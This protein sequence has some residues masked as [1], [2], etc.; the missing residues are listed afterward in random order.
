MF[1]TFMLLLMFPIFYIFLLF[2]VIQT[3]LQVWAKFTLQPEKLVLI[4]MPIVGQYCGGSRLSP[5]VSVVSWLE[6][7][8]LKPNSFQRKLKFPKSVYT[9]NRLSEET[10]LL[11]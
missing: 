9:P 3:I 7:T 5:L 10:I 2:P 1:K 8:R 4:P 6:L 11:S